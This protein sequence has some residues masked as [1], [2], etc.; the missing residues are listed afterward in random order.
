LIPVN[1]RGKNRNGLIF[2]LLAS[3]QGPNGFRGSALTTCRPLRK[4]EQICCRR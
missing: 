3:R 2:L 1:H 4:W